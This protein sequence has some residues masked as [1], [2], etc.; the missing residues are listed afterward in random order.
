MTTSSFLKSSGNI[1][2][3][4]LLVQAGMLTTPQLQDATKHAG[5]KRLQIGQILVMY[6]Y[7]TARDL[8][9]ALAAQSMLR[10][11]TVDLGQVLRSLKVAYKTG[12]RFEDV[13][14]SQ[15]GA[16]NLKVKTGKLGELLLDAG[17]ITSDQFLTSMDQSLVTGLPLGRTLVLDQVISDILLT[18]AL[19]TQIRLRDQMLSREEAIAV[20]QAAAGI[21]P[22]DGKVPARRPGPQ[23]EG[24][25]IGELLVMATLSH[26]LRCWTAWSELS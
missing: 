9:S 6:G 1:R 14:G 10:D 4:E 17:I 2:I 18:T 22:S 26:L 5:A 7:L 3:G 8:Q 21:I 20:L 11:R 16:V 12:S 19:D 15:A 13:I 23:R 24:L 25:R